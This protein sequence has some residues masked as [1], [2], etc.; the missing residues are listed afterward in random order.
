LKSF[1]LQ[2][3]MK[4]KD[5]PLAP[6]VILRDDTQRIWLRFTKPCRV[7]TTYQIREVLP[8]I[9][10]IEEKTQKDNLY[11]AGFLSYESAP[12]FDPSLSVRKDNAFPLLWF[13]LFEQAE[14]FTPP[15]A[16]ERPFPSILWHSSVTPEHYRRR[17]NSI[18][19]LIHD[20]DTYQVNFTYRLSAQT[21]LEPWLLF[22][23]IAGD[24]QA[25]FAA[26]ADTG[27]W[28]ILSASP[29]LFLKIDGEQI[30]SRPMKGTAARGLWFEDDQSKKSLLGHSDKDRA[31]NVMIT[32]MV[33]NDLGRIATAGS[34]RVSSLFRIERYPTVWQMTS[35]VRAQTREPLDKIL[36]ATF[37]PA[38]I[39][40]APKH[41]TMEIIANLEST[42]RRIYTGAIG[43]TAPGRRAQFSVAIRTILL[44][45]ESG[46]AEYGVG[47]GIVWD[48]NPENEYKECL[49]KT[50]VLQ[51]AI[52]NF[53]LLETFCWTPQNGYRLLDAHLKRLAQS[54]KYFGFHADLGRI[55]VELDKI[56]NCLPAKL[57]RIRLLVSRR[58]SIRCEAALLDPDTLR[59]ESVGL[60]QNPVDSRDVFLY[61]KTTRRQMYENAAGTY[62]K[63]G[64]ILLFNEARQI[65]EST[66][67]NVAV[68][69]DGHLYTPPVQCGLLPGT[70]RARLLGLG[71]IRERIISIEDVL[72]SESIYL[73]NS[74]RGMH[75]IQI[76]TFDK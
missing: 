25:P 8:L 49:T 29:E 41:R 38:S 44:H 51:P 45:K 22:L 54:A 11:A 74:V 12:A 67:A 16:D 66:V 56:A 63:S 58:G 7:I 59:F 69:I 57:H 17:I 14:T 71:R 28:A 64:D 1:A 30:E 47:G 27:E 9:R 53:D 55:R 5:S 34:V 33:R 2:E 21:N 3:K 19:Q 68:S 43:F 50:K 32:D 35:R 20:G 18:R 13:G 61:H 23:R 36:Q 26:Y 4:M 65:T 6:C 31:E 76:R 10:E 46:L 75:K 48:S 60:A 73:M 52:R 39:T 72:K 24:E 62:A 40:G 42:P 70:E 37:P 15:A